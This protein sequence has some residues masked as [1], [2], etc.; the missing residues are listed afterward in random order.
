MVPSEDFPAVLTWFYGLAPVDERVLMTELWMILM[1][2]DALP[3]FRG[4]AKDCI[5]SEG[6]ADIKRRIPALS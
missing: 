2:E 5:A 1:G 6:W 4:M 3:W